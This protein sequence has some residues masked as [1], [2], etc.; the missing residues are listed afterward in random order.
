LGLLRR[1]DVGEYYSVGTRVQQASHS[2]RIVV[3]GSSERYGSTGFYGAEG[4]SYRLHIIGS[5]LGIDAE[6]VETGRR[7]DFGSERGT[8][9]KPTT[10][11][12]FSGGQCFTDKVS[13]Y[14]PI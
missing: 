6:P 11:R 14:D 12:G 7:H 8:E 13:H 2:D 4:V 10:Y 5:M 3:P 1:A 9:I